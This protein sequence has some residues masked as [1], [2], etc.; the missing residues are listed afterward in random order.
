MVSK[1]FRMLQT[2]PEALCKL[3]EMD[4]SIKKKLISIRWALFNAFPTTLIE[5]SAENSQGE[6]KT[7]IKDGLPFQDNPSAFCNIL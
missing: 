2:L 1:I 4:V 6:A 7:K 3:D 5:V